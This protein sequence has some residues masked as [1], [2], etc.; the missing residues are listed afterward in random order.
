MFD[1]GFGGNRGGSKLEQSGEEA[2]AKAKKRRGS[3]KET[4]A[5]RLKQ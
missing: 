3:I 2:K 4:H 5:K 1:F